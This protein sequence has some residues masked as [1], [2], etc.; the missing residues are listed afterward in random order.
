MKIS[1]TMVKTLRDR[2]GA[3]MMDCKRV[4]QETQGDE[5]AAVDLLRA[6]G[7]AKAA[8]RA[9]RVA[10]EGVVASYIHHGSK[11]GVLVEINCETDFVAKTEEFRSLAHHVAMHVAASDPIAISIDDVDPGLVERERRVFAEQVALEGKPDHIRDRIVDGKMTKYFKQHV[12]L[13]QSYI[14]D[15]ERSVGQLVTETAARTGEKI[16]V[17]R[18]ARYSVGA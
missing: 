6:K 5:E 9:D 3:G 15:P 2:T 8:K 14:K 18:F 12:L 1:A 11:I 13:E 4:L 10:K 7:V 17:A 16:R